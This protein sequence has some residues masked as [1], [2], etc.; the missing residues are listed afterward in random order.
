MQLDAA[1]RETADYPSL[2]ELRRTSR[3]NSPYGL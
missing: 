3:L 1:V 2:C